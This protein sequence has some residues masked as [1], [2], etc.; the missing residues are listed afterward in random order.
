MQWS[1]I[2]A[3]T[4]KVVG[5][6]PTPAPNGGDR[7]IRLVGTET[8]KPVA[9]GGLTHGF[10]LS[11]TT[12][13]TESVLDNQ[14]FGMWLVAKDHLKINDGKEKERVHA[15]VGCLFGQLH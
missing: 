4:Q 1:A 12:Y 7:I 9:R 8:V 11:T 2:L 6:N 15:L 3:H 14:P 10:T 13:L 5:S